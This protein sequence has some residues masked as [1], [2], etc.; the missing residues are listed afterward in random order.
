MIVATPFA[1]VSH[2]C[3]Y[4][5]LASKLYMIRSIAVHTVL[6]AL[7]R[8]TKNERALLTALAG[9]SQK[10]LGAHK[11][12]AIATRHRELVDQQQMSRT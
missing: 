11:T 6:E 8:L 10:L 9:V 4:D 2:K 3:L 1:I 12:K 5:S 7:M